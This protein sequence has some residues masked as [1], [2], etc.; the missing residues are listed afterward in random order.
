MASTNM[1]EEAHKE[2]E[3]EEEGAAGLT[4]Q[5]LYSSTASRRRR[6]LATESG[7]ARHVKGVC[8]VDGGGEG[9][10]SVQRRAHPQEAV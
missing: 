10:A 8:G 1:K 5:D 7:R 2:E 9:G 6:L 4:L 3:E